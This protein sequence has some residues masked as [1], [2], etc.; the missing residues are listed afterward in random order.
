MTRHEAR[1]TAF[2]ILFEKLFR[3]DDGIDEIVSSAE[4]SEFFQVDD[5]ILSVTGKAGEKQDEIDG[6]IEKNLVGW[7]IKRISKVSLAVLRLAVCEIL[8]FDDIPV[9]VSINE[10]VE[11]TKKYSTAQDASFVNGVLGSVSKS[12][13]E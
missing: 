3:P 5:F 6:M 7:T 2:I 8:Y 13:S 11:I 9:S 12:V 10:A 4:E 1:E